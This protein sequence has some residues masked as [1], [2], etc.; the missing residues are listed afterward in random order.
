MLSLQGHQVGDF[1]WGLQGRAQCWTQQG[2]P[3]LAGLAGAEDAS[4]FL[5]QS[6]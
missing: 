4:V 1:V 3:R 2:A 6:I 5:G